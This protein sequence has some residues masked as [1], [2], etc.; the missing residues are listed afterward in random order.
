MLKGIKLLKSYPMLAAFT[1]FMLVVF[2][3]DMFATGKQYSELENRS[4]KQRPNFSWASL[5]KN[6]YT[7]KYEEF[8]NDQF[9]A[10]VSWISLKSV[11]ETALGKVENN[12]VA[13][14]KHGFLFG[15]NTT[16]NTP[17]LEK[18]IGFV[19]QFL[20]G[21]NGHMTL[22]IIPNSYEKLPGYLPL[23][24]AKIQVQQQPLMEDIYAQVK[25]NDLSTLEISGLLDIDEANPAQALDTYYR[26]DHHWTTGSAYKAYAAYC[27]SRGLKAVS[28]EELAPLRH[29]EPGFYGTYFS[30]AKKLGTPPDTLVWYDI[31]VTSVTVNGNDYVTDDKNNK[32]PLEG[33]FQ[34]EKLATRDKYAMFLYGNNG[35]TVIKS[36][37]NRNKTPGKT[38]RLLMVKDS[39]SNCL[40]PFLTYSY[41]E[42]YVIDLRGL[43][44]SFGKLAKSVDF[45]DLLLLYNYESFEGDMNLI[46]MT[47]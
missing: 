21:Y 17:R 20:A 4:L 36:D 45:D 14:G 38:S 15:K 47:L 23:G 41:D 42:L 1:A 31:P 46:R 12:G 25:G 43:G 35:L 37:N 39:Y 34:K 16:V 7:R 24:L 19:N 27:A 29:S 26:T 2:V 11:G 40:I 22:G 13:Y 5:A 18:N 6:E 32:I 3:A 9:V 8:I 28:L 44:E 30:K 33:L 10:R